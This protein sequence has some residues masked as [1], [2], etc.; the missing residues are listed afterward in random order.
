MKLEDT[1]YLKNVQRQ[2]EY[3][4]NELSTT[5]DMHA[6]DLCTRITFFLLL[7]PNR[8]SDTERPE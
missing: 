6:R 8:L 1:N 4:L 7:K 3:I 5:I 2:D